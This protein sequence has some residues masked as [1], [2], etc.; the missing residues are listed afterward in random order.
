MVIKEIKV[1]NTESEFVKSYLNTTKK[2]SRA[3]MWQ[4]I[5]NTSPRIWL[6]LIAVLSFIVLILMLLMQTKTQ[7][8]IISTLGLFAGAA[9]RLLPSMHRGVNSFLK[10][11]YYEPLIDKM[12]NELKM[13]DSASISKVNEKINSI[14]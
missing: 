6:E 5:I 12:H 1:Y 7:I 3:D 9:F 4:N 8:S 13:I 11:K 2:V 14:F 10:L